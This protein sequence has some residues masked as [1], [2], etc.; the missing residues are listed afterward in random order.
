MLIPLQT[1]IDKHG[2]SIRGVLHLGAHQAEEAQ[3][4]EKAGAKQVVWIEGNP[5]LMPV[6]TEELKKYPN[7]SAHNVLVSDQDGLDV[8]FKVTNNFQSSSMLELGTHKTHHPSVEVHH[9][10]HLKTHRLDTYLAQNN[11]DTTECNFLNIDL[12]GAELLALKGLGN[13]LDTIDYIYTEVN[14]GSVYVGCAKMLELDRYLHSRGFVR[15]ATRL[16]Q[17]Q[18]GD[19]L[20]VR[21]NATASEKWGNIVDAV[22]KQISYSVRSTFT[23]VVKLPRRILRKLKSMIFP[24]PVVTVD[25]N[26][27]GEREVVQSVVKT[28]QG[29]LVF[30]DVGANVGAYTEMI[31]DVLKSMNVAEYE[32]H[33]FEPQST[34][35]AKLHEKF[36]DNPHIN[37]NSFALSDEQGEALIH[38][39]FSGS[40]SASLYDRKEIAL[41]NKEKIKLEK[42][43]DYIKQNNID[44]IDLLKID[45]EGNEKRVMVGADS[46]LQ[47]TIVRN[48]QFEYG[49]TY[50]DAG[51]TLAEVAQLLMSKGYHVGKLCAA[52]IQF[53]D[54][55]GEFEENYRYSNFIASHKKF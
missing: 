24:A 17:W 45:T 1:L 54:Q 20:Y 38:A 52:Q 23:Q 43:S 16:T 33:L 4:Y 32:I 6:L 49:G 27:N 36:V 28:N 13:R 7:Q 48:I 15:T 34:C 12:Q 31:L 37:L 41:E 47:P 46:F 53:K 51:I 55:L 21:K 29:K 30:F 9:T 18:W 10:L 25:P 19:A 35:Y 3:D 22:T 8:S 50:L 14:I 2:V 5:E 39:D 44:R 26:E 42:L 40:S 11:V